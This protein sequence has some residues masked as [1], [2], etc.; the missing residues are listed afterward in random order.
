MYDLRH[1]GRNYTELYDAI[2]YSVGVGNW[3]HPME[4]LWVVAVSD[5]STKNA[6]LLY[7]ELQRY[8]GIDDSLL[9][10]R[11]DF[12]DQQGWLPKS[13]WNW[14]KEQKFKK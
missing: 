9:V 1:P 3:Q 13:F 5:F 4:S 7:T 8:L 14:F 12:T 11:M 6:E 10:S 2:K